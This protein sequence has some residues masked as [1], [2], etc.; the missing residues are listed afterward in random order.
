MNDIKTRRIKLPHVQISPK[1][2]VICGERTQ[3]HL[4]GTIKVLTYNFHKI[5][6]RSNILWTN[7]QV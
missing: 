2:Y 6:K 5:L 3:T 7:D 4:R 1:M